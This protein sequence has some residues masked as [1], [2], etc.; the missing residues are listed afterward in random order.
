MFRS[1]LVPLD[2]S[3]LAEQAL[4]LA[5]EI[6]GR[7]GA[8]L[9][10]ARVHALYAFEDPAYAW[11]P[12][13]PQSAD[14]FRQAEQQYLE[15]LAARHRHERLP[16]IGCTVVDGLVVDALLERAGA[17]SA[18]LIVMTTHGRGPTS[19]AFLGS[20]ADEMVRRCPIPL[21]LVRP[22]A[23]L[24]AGAAEPAL[25]NILV[26]LDLS[27]ESQVVIEPAL[28][29]AACFGA[30]V[31]LLHVIEPEFA[32][33]EATEAASGIGAAAALE[34]LLV[35]AGELA[36]C[37]GVQRGG[38]GGV[39][40]RSRLVSG[41]HVASA[42]VDEADSHAYDLIALATHGRGGFRRLLLGSVA[43][44]VLRSATCPVLSYRGRGE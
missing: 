30:A 13:N 43:D 40:I 8:A 17:I 16:R 23:T 6:A 31:T 27:L 34:R 42:I 7:A 32:A 25:R 36:Q 14:E 18:D 39:E 4:P 5:R 9:E 41:S 3:A 19:R 20:V 26:P 24:A 10:L 44:K 15:A 11:A 28:A 33:A 37:A 12:F 21:V 22:G 2:G 38:A 35:H 29:L 1:L